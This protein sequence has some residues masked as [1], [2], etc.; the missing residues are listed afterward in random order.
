VTTFG[1]KE[2]PFVQT[3]RA[4]HPET[5]QFAIADMQDR[6]S[7]RAIVR[8]AEAGLGP[9][10]GLVN[11]AGIAAEGLL[12][13][14]RADTIDR[15]IATNLVGT[16]Q[17]TQFT[18]RRM[19]L[20]RAG[21]IVNISSIIGLR[22][23]NGLSVYAATKAAIDGMTRAL[24]RELGPAGIRVNSVAPGYLKTEMTHGLTDD[25]MRQI[26][27]RTPLGRLGTPDDVVGLVQFLLSDAAA[28]ITGQTIA[29]EGGITC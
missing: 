5:F 10:F 26:A 7:L 28:F 3:C 6:D 11:N 17:L 15:V 21:S 8:T 23:Y 22:G 20:K 24:A 18:I 13:T 14:G 12:A 16:L 19:L 29:V 9:I 4:S 2:V 1:R 25:Q 27:N